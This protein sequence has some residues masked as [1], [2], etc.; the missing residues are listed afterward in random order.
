MTI[1]EWL[2]ALVKISDYDGNW[3]NYLDKLYAY[4]CEDFIS[5][6]SNYRGLK[7][8]IKRHPLIEQKEAT[9]WH[10]ITKSENSEERIPD[11]ERCERIRWP[12]P[13]IEKVPS[14]QI[15]VWQNR[16]RNETRVCLW[17]E[18]AEYLVILSERKNFLL[19]WT[20][21]PVMKNHRK[22]KLK[23]EYESSLKC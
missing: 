12:K 8:C 3:N 10:I 16:R 19:L 20:A 9:F 7:V 15:K 22:N 23:K 5:S 6:A 1:P 4:F 13:I 14:S 17:F 18:N 2:P 11:L 21:Y